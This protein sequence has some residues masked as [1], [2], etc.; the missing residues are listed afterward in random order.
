M[1]DVRSFSTIE[2]LERMGSNHQHTGYAPVALPLTELRS[3]TAARGLAAKFLKGGF[4]L[5]FSEIHCNN[6]TYK[7]CHSMSSW[8]CKELMNEFY[9]YVS[10]YSSFV[11]LLPPTSNLLYT[12]ISALPVHLRFPSAW[13]VSRFS[14]NIWLFPGVLPSG[15]RSAHPE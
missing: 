8:N 10:S 9:V 14:D 1:Y 12:A 6:I 2:K 7:V 4:H 5:L 15:A 13:S 11:Q 3:T